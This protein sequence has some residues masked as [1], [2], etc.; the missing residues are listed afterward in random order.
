MLGR[1][2]TSRHIPDNTVK[3]TWTQKLKPP[4]DVVVEQQDTGE[5]IDM[6]CLVILNLTVKMLLHY[7][8][9]VILVSMLMTL[10][11]VLNVLMNNQDN[12]SMS[13]APVW[14]FLLAKL[15]MSG[16]MS[17]KNVFLLV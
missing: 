7:L 13:K 6:L 9:P 10:M 5:K 15:V 17:G 2:P 1:S 8:L 16:I 11:E 3:P 12:Q 4:L 14:I